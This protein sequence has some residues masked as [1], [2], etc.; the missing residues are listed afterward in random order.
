[1]VGFTGLEDKWV[2][3]VVSE[4]MCGPIIEVDVVNVKEED[5]WIQLASSTCPTEENH[6]LHLAIPVHISGWRVVDYPVTGEV[7]AMILG[8]ISSLVNHHMW[9][10]ARSIRSVKYKSITP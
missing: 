8:V 7:P 1:M 10:K 6:C 3:V 9:H 2:D 4:N 5:L